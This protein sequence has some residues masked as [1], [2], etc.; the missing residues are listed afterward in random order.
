MEGQ[1]LRV[2]FSIYTPLVDMI[3]PAVVMEVVS[4]GFMLTVSPSDDVDTSI[5]QNLSTES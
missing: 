1:G 4:D 2:V 5:K 3:D